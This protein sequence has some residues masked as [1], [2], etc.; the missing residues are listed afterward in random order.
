MKKIVKRFEAHV[1]FIAGPN[2]TES[3]FQTQYITRDE[4]KK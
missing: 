3:D 2:M 1:L 4:I